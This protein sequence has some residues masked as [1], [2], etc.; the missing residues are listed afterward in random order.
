MR[1]VAGQGDLPAGTGIDSYVV[2]DASADYQ[3]TRFAQVFGSIRNLG[4]ATYA[5]ARRPAGLR[6]GLPRTVQLGV[7]VSF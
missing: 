7:R 5:V 3:V 6:R 1:T 4:D 2:F